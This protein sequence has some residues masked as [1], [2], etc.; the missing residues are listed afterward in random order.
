LNRL[1]TYRTFDESEDGPKVYLSAAEEETI[2][3][4]LG[5]LFVA[6]ILAEIQAIKLHKG[7]N[8]VK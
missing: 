7:S 1:C 3:L 8:F 5:S 2:Q 4:W 6:P